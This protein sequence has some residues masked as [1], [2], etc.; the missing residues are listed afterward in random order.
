MK[1][2][3]AETQYL[4]PIAYF[5]AIQG[6]SEIVIERHEH[7]MKQSYRN[8]CHIR[9]VSGRE[10]LIIP[11]T[12]KH[13]KTVITQVKID[14]SQKWLN[15]HWRTVQ[16]A[17]RNA[18]FFEYYADEL[19]KVLFQKMTFLYDLNMAL[20]SMC[21][22]WLKWETAIKE[23]TH[24]EKTPAFFVTDIRSRLNPKKTEHLDEFFTPAPYAQVF[25]SNFE[26]NLSLIDLIFCAGPSSS[27]IVKD[28]SPVK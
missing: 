6:A 17:Y 15:N 28:S 11:L 12:G 1:T 27:K 10:N 3:L 9:A 16:S 25:G 18:P 26:E 5:A 22:G 4:P 20:L 21:L 19:E 14:Y 2:V 7:Y 24:F 23:T 8:R 13:G